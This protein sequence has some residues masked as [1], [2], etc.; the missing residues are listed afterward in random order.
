MAVLVA[1]GIESVK[2]I[3]RGLQARLGARSPVRITVLVAG[4]MIRE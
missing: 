2:N 3:S 1:V 4:Q